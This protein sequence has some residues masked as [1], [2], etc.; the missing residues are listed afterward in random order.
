MVAYTLW[1]ARPRVSAV[2]NSIPVL[3]P[4]M[5]IDAMV[6]SLLQ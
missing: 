3:A 1:P 5:S 6:G 2:A 4:V